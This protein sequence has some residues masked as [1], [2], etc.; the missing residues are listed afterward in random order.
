MSDSGV[1]RNSQREAFEAFVKQW[2]GRDIAYHDANGSAG[3]GLLFAWDCWQEAAKVKIK[4]RRDRLRQRADDSDAALQG[5]IE[6]AAHFR[7]EFQKVRYDAAR[8]RTL[9]K[10]GTLGFGEI[11]QAR[12]TVSLPVLDAA[13]DTIEAIVDRLAEA[14][15]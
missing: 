4:D 8:W 3:F 6:A 15:K 11:G 9:V 5:T 14:D 1:R 2:T 12:A 10:H 13:D 7:N